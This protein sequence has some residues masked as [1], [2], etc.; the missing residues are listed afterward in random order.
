[1]TYDVCAITGGGDDSDDGDEDED[2]EDEDGDEVVEASD[3]EEEAEYEIGEIHAS[4]MRGGVTEY[5]VQWGAPYESEFT[6]EP[7]EHVGSGEALDRFM[8][9]QGSQ[10]PAKRRKGQQA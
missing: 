3:S 4:R 1:M 2:E 8:A 5:L 10:P 9:A 6:W 7:E